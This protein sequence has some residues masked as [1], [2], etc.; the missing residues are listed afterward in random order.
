MTALDE[1]IRKLILKK[2]RVE[3][4]KKEV[5]S[6]FNT[7][8]KELDDRLYGLASSPEDQA[9]LFSSTACDVNEKETEDA[10]YEVVP[11]LGSGKVIDGETGEVMTP[12]LEGETLTGEDEEE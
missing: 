10:D 1:E 7:Q 3:N 2:R 4:E 12:L 5:V 9:D 11:Q 6:E 8:I